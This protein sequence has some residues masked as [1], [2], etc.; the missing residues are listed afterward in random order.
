ML[1]ILYFAYVF[2]RC[3]CFVD[4]LQEL[5]RK[6]PIAWPLWV[7]PLKIADARSFSRQLFRLNRFIWKS[8]CVR[9]L[10]VW[11]ILNICLICKYKH[12]VCIDRDVLLPMCMNTRCMYYF[13]FVANVY[14][15]QWYLYELSKFSMVEFYCGEKSKWIHSI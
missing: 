1:R 8:R 13:F 14:S 5:L 11:L 9:L 3:V 7:D 4:I 2:R 12:V 10:Y 15:C 6:R